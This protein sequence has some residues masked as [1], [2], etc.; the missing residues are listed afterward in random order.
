MSERGRTDTCGNC[1]FWDPD[2]RGMGE[3][4]RGLPT[5]DCTIHGKGFDSSRAAW[6]TTTPGM[7]CGDFSDDWSK[8]Y[9]VI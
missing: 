2:G 5:R 4:H 8:R 7:W 1:C 3:C 9:S 6:L